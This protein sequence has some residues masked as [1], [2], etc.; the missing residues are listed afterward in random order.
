V[1]R[2]RWTNWGMGLSL[3]LRWRH[4][5]GKRVCASAKLS[6]VRAQDSRRKSLLTL[7]RAGDAEIHAALVVCLGCGR[8]VEVR[9]W[10]L[11]C[12]LWRKVPQ[13]LAYDGVVLDFP[14][15]LI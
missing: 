1:C 5:N 7:M 12:M 15:V 11:F 13:G 8:K 10:N 6:N 2:C 3:I 4:S 14:L 9:E